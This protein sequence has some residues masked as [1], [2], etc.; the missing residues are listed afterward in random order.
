[1]NPTPAPQTNPSALSN[2]NPIANLLINILLPVLALSWLSKEGDRLWHLGPVL[3][4]SLAVALPVGYGVWHYARTRKA[5]LFSMLGAISVLL[6]GGLTLMLWQ[7]DGSVHPNAAMLFAIK[8]AS[9]PL[10]LSVAVLVSHYT[11]NSLSRMLLFNP[12][13]LDMQRIHSHLNCDSS[14][15]RFQQLVFKGTLYICGAFLLSAALNGAVAWYFL[16][17]LVTDVTDARE[18]YN[19]AIGKITGWGFVIIAVPVTIVMI[20]ALLKTLNALEQITGLKRDDLFL[21]R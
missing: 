6:T 2:P 19:A 5:N 7:D 20:A 15:Q 1:M 9:I 10:V 3:G 21:P 8:E 4:M 13:L 17:D 16:G 11:P 18:H 12:E 14:K